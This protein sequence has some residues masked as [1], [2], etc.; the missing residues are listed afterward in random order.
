MRQ[1]ACAAPPE[2]RSAQRAQRGRPRGS[3]SQQALD[4]FLG[5]TRGLRGTVEADGSST[6]A[7]AASAPSS[8]PSKEP[9]RERC[10]ANGWATP[11][12]ARGGHRA[13]TAHH[14]AHAHGA[15]TTEKQRTS[16]SQRFLRAGGDHRKISHM[17]VNLALRE[18]TAPPP[19]QRRIIFR[20]Q[21]V[22]TNDN[23]GRALVGPQMHLSPTVA[24]V[25]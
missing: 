19:E 14:S 4:R 25:Q 8:K 18:P 24:P 5:A 6:S 10:R 17:E 2:L 15:D 11:P 3:S 16:R 22:A 1:A 23:C 13:S 9:L 21:D 20:M 7:A 12:R